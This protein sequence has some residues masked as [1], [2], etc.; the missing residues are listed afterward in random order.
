MNR[1]GKGGRG[2]SPSMAGE[3]LMQ[4]QV[5]CLFTVKRIIIQRLEGV[6]EFED[7]NGAS[8]LNSMVEHEL[9]VRCK[10]GDLLWSK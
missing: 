7:M 5:L 10:R 2:D 9:G 4:G 3:E 6:R 1:T 8:R